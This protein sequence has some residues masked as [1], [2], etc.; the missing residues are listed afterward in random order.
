MF[1]SPVEYTNTCVWDISI[2]MCQWLQLKT[3]NNPT[4]T[5]LG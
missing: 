3:L 4:F 1:T 2:F 5:P